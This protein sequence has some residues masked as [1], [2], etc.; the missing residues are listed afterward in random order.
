VF[1]SRQQL[2]A[3]ST[4]FHF[5]KIRKKKLWG[6]RKI[7]LPLLSPKKEQKNKTKTKTKFKNKVK[8]V[9]APIFCFV[10][11]DSV[12]VILRGIC[13]CASRGGGGGGRGGTVFLVRFIRD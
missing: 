3:Y 1:A 5:F 2:S 7:H 8:L 12:N 6:K 11:S 13:D 10:F 9:R 4:F